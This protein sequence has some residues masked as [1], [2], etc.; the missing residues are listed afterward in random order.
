M[1]RRKAVHR[2]E[3]RAKWRT[4]ERCFKIVR[5]SQL[6]GDMRDCRY[7]VAAEIIAN[8]RDVM[9]KDW[10]RHERAAK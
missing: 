1:E 4:F 10:K 7:M 3:T 9:A 2:S 8:I 6:K 5:R